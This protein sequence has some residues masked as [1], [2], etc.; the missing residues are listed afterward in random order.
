[1]NTHIHTQGFELTSAIEQHTQTQ[2]QFHLANFS[3]HIVAAD[4]FLRD[5][6]GPKG[7]PDKKVLIRV[8]LRSKIT[9]TIERTRSNLYTAVSTAARQAKRAV[10]RNLNKHRRMERFALREMGRV[11]EA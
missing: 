4:V 7:G 9:V 5:I 8:Q 2:L 6:N 1:M 3:A 10:R 11:T